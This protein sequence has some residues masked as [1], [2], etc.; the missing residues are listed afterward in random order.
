MKVW[1]GSYK[2]VKLVYVL[3]ASHMAAGTQL[4]SLLQ[5]ATLLLISAV[6]GLWPLVQLVIVMGGQVLFTFMSLTTRYILKKEQRSQFGQR[7]VIITIVLR[8]SAHG[9][10][11]LRVCPRGVGGVCA[12]LSVSA[13]NHERVPMSCLYLEAN[14]WTNNIVKR[15]HHFWSQVLTTHNTLNGTM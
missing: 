3:V 12:L 10:S 2:G 14:N 6:T 5:H 4:V 15:N 11:A 8:K 7:K 13:F 9:Q 1:I